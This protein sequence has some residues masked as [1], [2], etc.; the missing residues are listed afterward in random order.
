M[1]KDNKMKNTVKFLDFI[2]LIGTLVSACTPAAIPAPTQ[3]PTSTPSPSANMPNPAA[4]FCQQQG[5]T[6]EICTATDGSQSG[7]C[8]FP[9]GTE[10]DEWA[11]FR[12]ECSPAQQIRV[13]EADQGKNFTLNMGDSLTVMLDSNPSTGYAWV[14]ESVDNPVLLLDGE[15]VFKS[16]SSQLGAPGKATITFT[17]VHIGSQALTLLYQRPFEKDAQPLKTFS[18]NV[19]VAN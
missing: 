12:Q 13:T 5:Y 15:P 16:D 18:I 17:T 4:A 19:T 7:V 11:Y 3:A 14:V 2:L 1:E 8:K 9:D 6:S 10:C